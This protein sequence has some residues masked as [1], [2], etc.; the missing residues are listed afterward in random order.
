MNAEER[1]CVTKRTGKKNQRIMEK[2]AAFPVQVIFSLRGESWQVKGYLL[3]VSDEVT[4]MYTQTIIYALSHYNLPKYS[5]YLR[6]TSDAPD[7]LQSENGMSST[8]WILFP[9]CIRINVIPVITSPD[10]T[11]EETHS[12]PVMWALSPPSAAPMTA[13][14]PVML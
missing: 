5:L 6:V 13:R 11:K 9:C 8:C 1:V 7:F 12:T 2:S 10:R 14:C 4:F 3:L